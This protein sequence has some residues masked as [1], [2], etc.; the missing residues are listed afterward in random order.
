MSIIGLWL[1]GTFILLFIGMICGKD[2]I[3]GLGLFVWIAGGLIL[4]VY[5][6]LTIVVEFIHNT[7]NSFRLKKKNDEYKLYKEEVLDNPYCYMSFDKWKE[8]RNKK[9]R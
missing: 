8:E 2:I 7:L 9:K 1:S 4:S 5:T 3:L 6:I